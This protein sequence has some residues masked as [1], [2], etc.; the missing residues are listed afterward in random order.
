MN[1]YRLELNSYRGLDNSKV[2]IISEELETLKTLQQLEFI[3]SEK[4][5]RNKQ[6]GT[7]RKGFSANAHNYSRDA[8]IF[9]IAE[10]LFKEVL[11]SEGFKNYVHE[12][13]IIVKDTVLNSHIY[14]ID[15]YFP[16]LKLAIEIN[17]LFHYTYQNVL[18]RDQLRSKLLARKHGIKTLDVKVL[19]KT[20]KGK[21]LTQLEPKST[22]LAIN[23]LK[24]H[25]DKINKQT[26]S[27]WV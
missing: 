15:F 9:S 13:K 20:V 27:Y 1:A 16:S 25:S 11:E 17:P 21:F 12:L 18:I 10:E 3:A 8:K 22:K 5:K 19:H 7:I 23:Y 24:K 4:T 2:K 14:H 26:L 6:L